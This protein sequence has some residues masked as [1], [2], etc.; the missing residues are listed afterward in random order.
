MFTLGSVTRMVALKLA[1]CVYLCCCVDMG[2]TVDSGRD[3]EYTNTW[4]ANIKGGEEVAQRV[5]RELGFNFLGQVSWL[6]N[7]FVVRERARCRPQCS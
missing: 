2:V 5:A 6:C 4:L 7:T 1:A 3:T